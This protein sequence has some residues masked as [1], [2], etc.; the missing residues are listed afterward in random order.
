MYPLAHRLLQSLHLPA[1]GHD[2]RA[3]EREPGPAPQETSGTA[4]TAIAAGDTASAVPRT[5]ALRLLKVAAVVAVPA[6]LVAAGLVALDETAGSR[7][8]ARLLSHAAGETA[9]SLA[10]GPSSAIRF[11]VTGPYDL[12]LGYARL[13]AFLDRL[14]GAGAPL[15][16]QARWSLG[17]LDLARGGLF[18]AYR[19]KDQAGL[20]IL[21]RSGSP[22]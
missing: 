1:W 3:V 9:Y 5:S 15:L 18:P 16:A 13:P 14:R 7:L 12:R 4:R 10:P 11:P 19:E 21:D 17:L 8:Q 22:L 20:S 2:P 6:L